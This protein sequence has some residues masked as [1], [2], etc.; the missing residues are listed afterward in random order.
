MFRNLTSVSAYRALP[1]DMAAAPAHPT[2]AAQLVAERATLVT[3]I[4]DYQQRLAGPGLDPEQREEVSDWVRALHE[5]LRAIDSLISG[6]EEMSRLQEK[7]D[8]L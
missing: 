6:N 2:T 8:Q 1:E 3:A 4:T 7:I 5:Q